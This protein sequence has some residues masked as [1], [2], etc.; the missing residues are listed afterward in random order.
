MAYLRSFKANFGV[1]TSGR[2]PEVFSYIASWPR[3]VCEGKNR[4][5]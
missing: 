1:L 3:V 4:K 5:T 2:V